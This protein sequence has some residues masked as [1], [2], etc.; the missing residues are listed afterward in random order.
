MGQRRIGQVSFA[1][2]LLPAQWYWLLSIRNRLFGLSGLFI[3]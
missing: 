1:E 3:G 2:A